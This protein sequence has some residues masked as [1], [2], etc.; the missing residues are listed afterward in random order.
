MSRNCGSD[1]LR[2][3]NNPIRLYAGSA[4]C[5]YK[6]ISTSHLSVGAHPTLLVFPCRAGGKSTEARE[7]TFKSLVIG[8]HVFMPVL[9][10]SLSSCV[11]LA[12]FL[13]PVVVGVHGDRERCSSG[14]TQ[15]YVMEL[16][17]HTVVAYE[18]SLQCRFEQSHL[19]PTASWTVKQHVITASMFSHTRFVRKTFCII[20]YQIFHAGG[21]KISSCRTIPATNAN[22]YQDMVSSNFMFIRTG[23]GSINIPCFSVMCIDGLQTPTNVKLVFG[24]LRAISQSCGFRISSTVCSKT[25]TKQTF[26]SAKVLIFMAMMPRPTRKRKP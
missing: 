25:V 10:A 23:R 16:Q 21:R 14:Y 1:F 15:R 11:T 19:S 12:R 8:W 18:Q 7:R 22:K 17:E 24:Q 4:A 9:L 26:P 3:C 6:N 20:E 5:A 13:K 2:Q